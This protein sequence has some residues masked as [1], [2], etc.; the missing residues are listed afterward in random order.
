M[1]WKTEAEIQAKITE[2]EQQVEAVDQEYEEELELQELEEE[3]SAGERLRQEF[4]FKQKQLEAQV[5]ILNWV[6]GQE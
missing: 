3:S 4:D 2:L 6:L 5:K 1:A